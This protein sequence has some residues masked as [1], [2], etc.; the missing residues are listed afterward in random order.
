[1]TEN[2][3]GIGGFGEFR[4]AADPRMLDGWAGPV[5]GYVN[6]RPPWTRA[7]FE[8]HKAAGYMAISVRRDAWW[9][10]VARE[11]DVETGAAL[12]EDV[13]GFALLRH[14]LGYRNAGVYVSLDSWPPVRQALEAAGVGNGLCR[15]RIADWTGTPRR[16]GPGQLGAGWEAWAHQFASD[17]AFDRNWAWEEPGWSHA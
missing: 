7:D 16:F 11:I 2:L 5:Q 8:A 15:V 9:A 14:H 6:H 17:G 12:P 10:H 13:P 1:M 4:D 3:V